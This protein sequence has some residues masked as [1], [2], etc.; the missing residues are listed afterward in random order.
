ML[1]DLGFFLQTNAQSSSLIFFV[2]RILYFWLTEFFYHSVLPSQFVATF[3]FQKATI[4][5][6]DTH[7]MIITNDVATFYIFI[8]SSCVMARF[9]CFVAK[10]TFY[11]QNSPWGKKVKKVKKVKKIVVKSVPNR[12]T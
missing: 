11:V 6:F 7:L 4:K 3:H 9:I 12:E 10:W 5:M 8:G 2:G 1:L